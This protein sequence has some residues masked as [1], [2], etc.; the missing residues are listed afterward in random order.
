MS[1]L[2]TILY[3]VLL[4]IFLVI[5]AGYV[6]QRK[7]N[8]DLNP[9]AKVQ[10]YLFVPALLFRNISSSRLAGSLVLKLVSFTIVL[11]LVLMVISAIVSKAFKLTKKRQ[12]AFINAVTLRN[13]GN[14]GIPV[15]SLVYA[16][17]PELPLSI[18]M[19]V[20]FTT[21]LLLN[22]VG[23]Y[24]ISSGTYSKIDAVK[25]V[26]RLP[27]LYVIALGFLFMEKMWLVPSPI[28]SSIQIMAAG[29]VPLALF[30]LG[31]QLARSQIRR[32]DWPLSVAIM[33]RLLL[34]PLLAY[35]LTL[36]FGFTG[37]EAQV[38][39]IGAAVPTAVNSVVLAMEF[40]GDT[41]YASETV[42]F[43]TLLSALTVTVIISLM[44]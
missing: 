20:L 4:P 1:N 27:I 36:I 11:F 5:L 23:L 8:M 2:L 12:K 16:A 22:T 34:S 17:D 29:V 9:F 39:I 13:M 26:L 25:Q 18:H 33:M 10:L 31:A 38:L 7:Y 19:I 21:S 15:I 35:G 3:E 41:N 6:M 40:E 37:I 42:F 30:T 32:P 14:F 28:D 44:T 24:N 43:T